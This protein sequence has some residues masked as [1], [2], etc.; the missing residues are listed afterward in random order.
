MAVGDDFERVLQAAQT[1]AD[2]AFTILY[3]EFN[4]RLMRYFAARNP[5]EAEDLAAETWMGVARRLHDFRGDEK[6]FRS[7]LFTIAHRRRS[8]HWQASRRT[9]EPVEPTAI[10]DL[11]GG[12]DPETIVMDA[13][14]T[15]GAAR[16]IA[17]VLTPDQ[18]EVVLLRL[19]GGLDVQQVAEV[20][21]KRP[22]TIRVHQHRALRKLWKEFAREGVTQ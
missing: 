14:S 13:L 10:A 6:G 20:L 3:A 17:A 18:A 7:W 4:P 11:A 8:D 5:A 2:W 15:E 1:G 19:L 9:H 21:G 12:V 22:G 16:R